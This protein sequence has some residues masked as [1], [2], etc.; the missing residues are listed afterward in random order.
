MNKPRDKAFLVILRP[1]TKPREFLRESYEEMKELAESALV[2]VLG[3]ETQ[4]IDRPSP[5]HYIREGKLEEVRRQAKEA[6]AN[7]LI[8]NTN[9][10]PAQIRNI[11]KFAGIPAVDV[12][13]ITGMPAILSHRV[14]TLHPKIHGAFELHAAAPGRARRR[15]FPFGRR[16]GQQRP[17]RNG[18]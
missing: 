8:F 5:S 15:A 3:F 1:H 7:V 2:R 6:G 4:S 11:E 10:S 14:L 16:R 17:G 9:L 13:E 12:A 18:T